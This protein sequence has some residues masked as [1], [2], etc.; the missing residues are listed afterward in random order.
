M[1]NHQP[2]AA[3]NQSAQK[4][5]FALNKGNATAGALGSG[6][7]AKITNPFKDMDDSLQFALVMKSV[8]EPI[9]T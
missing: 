2:I 8:D 7:V 1:V 6:W 4:Q 3:Q 5:D 9:Y